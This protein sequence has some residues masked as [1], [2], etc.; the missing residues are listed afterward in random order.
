MKTV[1]ILLILFALFSPTT[2]AQEYTQWSLPDGAVA[3]LG[4]G[5]IS[6]IRFSP[7]VTQVAIAGLIGIWFYDTATGQEIALLT[8]H[9]DWV[10]SLAFS[11]DGTTL[12]SG[13]EN[14]VYL[15]D[16]KKG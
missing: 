14:N 6:K 3:R 1:V 13:S 2:L 16:V 15:W 8:G 12:A 11:P 10:R 7:D 9:T 4:K 5:N